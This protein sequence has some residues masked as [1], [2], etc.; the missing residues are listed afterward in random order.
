MK[1]NIDLVKREMTL[2]SKVV[3]E[4]NTRSEKV[5]EDGHGWGLMQNKKNKLLL[6]TIYEYVLESEKYREMIDA[7]FKALLYDETSIDDLSH[8]LVVVIGS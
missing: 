8:L 2:I 1:K 4:K 3:G 7:R 5:F 6:E